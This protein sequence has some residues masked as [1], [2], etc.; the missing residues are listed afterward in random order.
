MVLHPSDL[1]PQVKARGWVQLARW[2]DFGHIRSNQAQLRMS[3]VFVSRAFDADEVF[4]AVGE[5]RPSVIAVLNA[6]ALCG[7]LAE[8]PVAANAPSL[9][10]LAPAGRRLGGL[11]QRLRGALG[12]GRP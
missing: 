1:L 12:I 6:C 8:T 11:I 7:L 4:E 10:H 2:P 5:P 9:A 3:A